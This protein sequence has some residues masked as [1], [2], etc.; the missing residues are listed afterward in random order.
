MRCAV[1]AVL[2]AGCAAQ[3]P[4]VLVP[5]ATPTPRG[6]FIICAPSEA[7]YDMLHMS[8]KERLETERVLVKVHE[9]GLPPDQMRFLRPCGDADL[10]GVGPAK[11]KPVDEASVVLTL[12]ATG[13]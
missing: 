2:L 4:H 3:K 12:F 10:I 13:S 7:C 9:D 6:W 11:G 5:T 8:A 1:L